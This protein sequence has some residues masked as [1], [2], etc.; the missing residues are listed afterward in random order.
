MVRVRGYSVFSIVKLAA[1]RQHVLV[2]ASMP[3]LQSFFCGNK[4]I[5]FFKKKKDWKFITT[6]K[7]EKSSIYGD[8]LGPWKQ[9][10]PNSFYFWGK[11]FFLF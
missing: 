2:E 4:F 7:E 10:P 1:E 8:P 9:N 5:S 6:L 3:A 11:E